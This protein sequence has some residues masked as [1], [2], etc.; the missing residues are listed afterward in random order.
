MDTRADFQRHASFL[1]ALGLHRNPKR[2]FWDP[3]KFG[4]HLGVDI[5]SASGM[6]YA[7][8]D[9]LEQLSHATYLIGRATRNRM[10]L[11]VRELQPLA[12]QAHYIFPAMSRR[13]DSSCGSSTPRSTT[14]GAGASG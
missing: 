2:G 13:Q 12:W 1:D 10:W 8:A 11:P 3:C 4:R 14:G 5:D 6:F 9:K 7:P